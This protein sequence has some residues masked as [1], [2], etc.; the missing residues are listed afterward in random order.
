MPRERAATLEAQAQLLDLIWDAIILHSLDGA[1]TYWNRASEAIYGWTKEEAI[2]G[3]VHALL[4]TEFPQPLEEIRKTV[5]QAGR[6]EGILIHSS[7]DGRRVTVASRWSLQKNEEGRPVAYLEIN[8]DITRSAEVEETRSRLA[9]IV[10]SSDDSIIGK[11]LDGTITSWNRGAQE[12]FGYAAEE[13]IGR[14]ISTLVPPDSPDEVPHILE[15][16]RRGDKV[17]HYRTVRMRKDGRRINVSLTVSPIRDASATITGASS[18]ARD[19][20]EQKRL[21]AELEETNAEL[22]AFAY[23]VSHDLKAPLRGMRGF[24][25]ALV[26]DYGDPLDADGR[27]YAER[28]MAAADRLHGMI[29]DLLAYSRV[30]RA[31]LKLQPVDLRAAVDAALAQ[32]ET[33]L[34]E[35]DARVTT[36][37]PLPEIVGHQ[38]TLVQVAA[39]LL[40][41]AVKFVPPDRRP[42]VRLWA[43]EGAGK[44]RLWVADNGI[45]ISPEYHQQVFRVF[46]RL[47]GDESYPGT[48]I[49]L[50]IVRKGVER[51]EGQVGLESELGGGSRF[52]VELPK[53]GREQ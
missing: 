43:E 24:A 11:T 52:W 13:I 46:E 2:G 16:I 20:T 6:W 33:P 10:E 32:L 3:N 27:E 38:A 9:A 49:G 23:S 19:I 22:E 53:S 40:S 18:I 28:V 25:Q 29:Q 26:E 34:R 7:R 48:G 47:H 17:D 31:K 14:S 36:Q 8:N 35:R 30:S 39:N 37:D 45:G 4:K 42:E 51:M 15:Q 1:I 41:N 5:D 44:V 12:L 50:A 21:E